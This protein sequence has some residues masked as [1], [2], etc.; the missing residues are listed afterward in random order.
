[1]IT[2]SLALTLAFGALGASLSCGQSEPPE[3][4]PEPRA[5]AVV[6]PA[7]PVEP[8]SAPVPLPTAIAAATRGQEVQIG[9]GTLRVGS[10]TGSRDRDPSREADDVVVALGAF[11]IDAL[12]Y[13]NDPA[14]APRTDVSRAEAAQLCAA[15]GK[16]LCSELEWERAC[17]GDENLAYPALSHDF[18]PARCKADVNAC[19]S[20]FGVFALG[21]FGREW[22]DGNVTRGLGDSLRTAV[23]RGAGPGAKVTQHRCAARDAATPDSKG[24][25][26]TFRCCRGP[27]NNVAYPQEPERARF[28]EKSLS[29]DELASL[30]KSQPALR[31]V[32]D[33][34][35]LFSAREIDEG[36]EAAHTS[37]MRMA[38]WLAAASVLV[39]SPVHGEEVWVL[40]GDT[41]RGAMLIA[42]YALADHQFSLIGSL[43]SRKEHAPFVVGYKPDAPE[44]LLFSTCWGC[45][46]EGG[47]IKLGQDSRVAIEPR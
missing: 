23:V 31:D 36:L 19:R 10:P 44:E 12:P 45:G 38:P 2:R 17:K 43:E 6:A 37:R 5:V 42:L 46:G 3:A 14:L 26:L 24:S 41:R 29:R 32:V 30:L 1:M 39:W 34:F 25:S 20:P 16:R 13:P 28:A 9:A 21:A 11:A 15:E 4:P 33:T 40:S 47:A 18:D 27:A 22:T 7:K 35:R 8:P